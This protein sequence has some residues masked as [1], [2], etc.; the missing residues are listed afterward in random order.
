MPDRFPSGW[1]SLYDD[2]I[3][4]NNMIV[5]EW[6]DNDGEHTFVRRKI[7]DE[8][9][10]E[11]L[12]RQREKAERAEE[13]EILMS[14]ENGTI[15][16]RVADDGYVRPSSI[17]QDRWCRMNPLHREYVTRPDFVRV[18]AIRT[19]ERIASIIS[20]LAEMGSFV[21]GGFARFCA[22]PLKDPIPTFDIDV[23]SVGYKEH[24]ELLTFVQRK[25]KL[26]IVHDNMTAVSFAGELTEALGVKFFQVIKPLRENAIITTGELERIL[27]SFDF[28]V[29]RAAL[30]APA[31]ALVDSN[32]IEDESTRRLRV[33]HYH[34]NKYH[35][36]R[37]LKYIQRGYRINRYE[38]DSVLGRI[39]NE[40]V[41]SKIDAA[42]R[43]KRD[44]KATL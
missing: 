4:V 14:L 19:P 39:S 11:E 1:F 5:E 2:D 42:G 44:R 30:I 7:W 16:L 43:K 35:A 23:F 27:E 29:C 6:V 20:E 3:D 41:R 15:E 25:L 8:S 21:C 28:S 17:A 40:K 31:E 33:R 36:A 24:A 34:D 38:I 13:L 26:R 10:E 12:R 37:L 32:F 9:S 18:A 22:S